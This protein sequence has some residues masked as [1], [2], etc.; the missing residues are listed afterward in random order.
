MSENYRNN[1]YKSDKITKFYH[2]LSLSKYLDR[3]ALITQLYYNKKKK[4][5]Y[6]DEFLNILN[7][8]K[9]ARLLE[10]NIDDIAKI[11]KDVFNEVNEYYLRFIVHK[12]DEYDKLYFRGD[13]PIFFDIPFNINIGEFL[14]REKFVD[15]ISKK[16]IDQITS[17]NE[18]SI[19][20]AFDIISL[21]GNIEI[22]NSIST[23]VPFEEKLL[24]PSD[25]LINIINDLKKLKFTWLKNIVDKI[26]TNSEKNFY[27]IRFCILDVASIF[28]RLAEL[29]IPTDLG[30]D[31]LS[32]AH[33]WIINSIYSKEFIHDVNLLRNYLS[34]LEQSYLY[35]DMI[36]KINVMEDFSIETRKDFE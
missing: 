8:R 25:L 28:I 34:E 20:L 33:Q 9:D 14:Q 24:L 12:Y 6:L 19:P 2:I 32:E 18:K 22:I 27:G 21:N 1:N 17:I 36:A 26:L 30:K 3:L 10:N 5:E 15:L 29:R 7:K 35:N 13:V 23:D 16:I 11:I 31:G 4:D